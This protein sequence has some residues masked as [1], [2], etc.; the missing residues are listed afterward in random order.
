LALALA[1]N[2]YTLVYSFDT[3]EEET[4]IA[5]LLRALAEHNIEFRDLRSNESSLEDIFVSL[6]HRPN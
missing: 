3:Q 4:G 2:R 6:L 1:D 5:E